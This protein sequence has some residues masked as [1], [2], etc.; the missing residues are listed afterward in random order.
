MNRPTI[1]EVKESKEY[2]LLK[3]K[4]RCEWLYETWVLLNWVII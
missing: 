3:E 2:Q 4:Y 1:Y